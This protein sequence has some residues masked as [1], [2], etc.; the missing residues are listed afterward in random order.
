MLNPLQHILKNTQWFSNT[1]FVWN[2]VS[3]FHSWHRLEALTTPLSL[4]P[5]DLFDFCNEEAKMEDPPQSGRLST[6]FFWGGVEWLVGWFQESF[7][8]F[9]AFFSWFFFGG[10]GW[11]FGIGDWEINGRITYNYSKTRT[12]GG[13]FDVNESWWKLAT[14]STRLR[15]RVPLQVTC[16]SQ[17]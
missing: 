8:F 3:Q 13:I 5:M 1:C 15:G 6:M 10:G 12:F 2:H 7:S 11:S 16:F 9:V 4:R 14:V 17:G